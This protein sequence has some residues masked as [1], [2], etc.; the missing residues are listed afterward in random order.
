M[1]QSLVT[2]IALMTSGLSS[3]ATE[4]LFALLPERLAG[5]VTGSATPGGG[6]AAAG[7]TAAA[8]VQSD[9]APSLLALLLL[10]AEPRAA[11]SVLVQLPS[12]FQGRVINRIVTSTAM[13]VIRGPREDATVVKSLRSQLAGSE[14]WGAASACRILRA[15]STTAQLKGA[16]A[17]AASHD[18]KAAKILQSHLFCFEDVL[19]LEDRELQTLLARSDNATLAEAM[20]RASDPVVERILEN[21]SERRAGLVR[22]E[23]ELYA[24]ATAEEVEAAQ[25]RIISTARYLSESGAI[26][27]YFG[28]L[29]SQPKLRAD[30]EVELGAGG[31][32]G[33][34][35]PPATEDRVRPARKRKGAAARR[36]LLLATPG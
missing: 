15:I 30:D 7:D 10:N 24:G 11:G 2:S 5:A 6:D 1:D 26:S 35:P 27:M 9:L 17:A 22:D 12:S 19:R 31:S 14:V 4:S 23:G 29:E 28:S 33:D 13:S 16:V 36:P 25:G 20:R 3:K 34:R 18:E 8:F 21:M 32:R